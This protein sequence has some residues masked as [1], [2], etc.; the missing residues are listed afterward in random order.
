[1]RE[2]AEAELV[3]MKAQVAAERER[4]ERAEATCA[5]LRALLR[6]MLDLFEEEDKDCGHRCKDCH[7][8]LAGWCRAGKCTSQARAVLA[9]PDPGADWL[10]DAWALA[11]AANRYLREGCARQPAHVGCL[12]C[13]DLRGCGKAQA[14]VALSAALRRAEARGWAEPARRPEPVADV[15]LTDYEQGRRALLGS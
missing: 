14:A 8:Y 7:D 1:M 9:A 6:D 11:A 10:A 5:A 3:R 13:A 15:D 4:A 12:G 2:A